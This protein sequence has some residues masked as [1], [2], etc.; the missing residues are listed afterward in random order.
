M[1]KNF[2]N[3]LLVL[4]MAVGLALTLALPVSARDKHKDKAAKTKAAAAK[5]VEAVLAVFNA[6]LDI[7]SRAV[8]ERSAIPQLEA[9]FDPDVTIIDNSGLTRGWE[10]YKTNLLNAQLNTVA[11]TAGVS[12]DA[13]TPT[14]E[15]APQIPPNHRVSDVAA[16]V[17]G[18]FAWVT[19]QYKL[20]AYVKGQAVPIFG[21]GTTIM[22][23][24]SSGWKI[25]H[26]QNAGRK[27]Q[28][29]DPQF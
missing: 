26:T 1:K 11:P 27:E 9:Y 6:V 20:T 18:D 10:T 13:E 28:S 3:S 14:T 29:Y 25:V 17:S 7:S 23:R 2:P 24:T 19:Y 4:L 15:P 16:R 12:R 5:D 21:Y 8:S 22:A